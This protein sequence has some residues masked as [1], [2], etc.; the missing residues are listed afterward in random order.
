MRAAFA[1]SIDIS[2]FRIV[3]EPSPW[4]LPVTASML[5]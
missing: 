3:Q 2:D 5:A 1:H 4:A